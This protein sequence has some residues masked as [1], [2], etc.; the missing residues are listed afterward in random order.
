MEKNLFIIYN[1]SKEQGSHLDAADGQDG[2]QQGQDGVG[3]DHGG[4][5]HGLAE[6]LRL[7]GDDTDGGGSGLA[8]IDGGDQADDG[9][10]QAGREDQQAA[11]EGDFHGGA[12]EE[13]DLGEGD[14]ADE[15]AV[16]ALG[17]GEQ[18]EQQDLGEL[19]GVHRGDA[20]SGLTGDLDADGGAAARKA[21]GQGDSD[22]SIH[23]TS[24]VNFP[25]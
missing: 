12:A 23:N 21:D 10:G 24:H 2:G 16:D 20:G 25:P 5:D 22:Q 19:A 4:E 3:L 14:E 1:V 17:A 7:L 13:A 9:D 15:Q 11:F 6:L 18:L 8:L